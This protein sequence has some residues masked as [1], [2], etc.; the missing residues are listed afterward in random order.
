MKAPESRK[1]TP[2]KPAPWWHSG[3]RFECQGSGKC[4][5]SRG[6]YGYVYVT[7][8]DRKKLGALL[9]IP[10]ASFTRK[11]CEKQDGIWKLKDFDENCRFLDGKRCNVYEARPTQC[12]TWPFWPETLSAKGWAKEVAAYCPGVGKG[13]VWKKEEIQKILSDQ[14]ASEDRY[15]T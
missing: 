8:E 15:G 13:R 12:R 11:Y 9:K 7:L 5:V 10:T 1:K 2:K 14:K 3:V 4:C 6:Q